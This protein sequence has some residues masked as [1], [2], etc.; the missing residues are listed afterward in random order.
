VQYVAENALFIFTPEFLS[1]KLW[2]HE[3]RTWGA[4]P[5]K[6]FGDGAQV[7]REMRAAMLGDYCWMMKRDAYETKYH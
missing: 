4:L 5:S 1:I 7:Q 6:H 3:R 2:W